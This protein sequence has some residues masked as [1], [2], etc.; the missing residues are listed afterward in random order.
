MTLVLIISTLCIN[1]TAAYQAD[2]QNPIVYSFFTSTGTTVNRDE[3]S[4]IKFTAYAFDNVDIASLTLVYGGTPIGSA[5][6]SLLEYSVQTSAM[7][8]GSNSFYVI[9]KDSA[10]NI[11]Y[12][13]P[14]YIT[15][16]KNESTFGPTPQQ[17]QGYTQADGTWQSR[18]DSL[19]TQ[20]YN[21]ADSYNDIKVYVNG[22][23]VKLDSQPELING[24]TMVPMRAVLEGMGAIVHWNGAKNTVYAYTSNESISLEIGS[25]YLYTSTKGTKILNQPGEIINQRAYI[26]VRAVTEAFDCN[27][28]WYND[29]K[30][31]SIVT[32]N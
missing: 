18:I 26:P 32:T 15:I 20:A 30:V 6:G 4:S 22:N 28:Q 8:I 17:G 19:H 23:R 31:V 14:I 10:G 24:T 11:G 5:S 16:T 29:K 13:A 3:I 7:Y 2:T 9:A 25:I 27:V 12:S 21:D 1:A